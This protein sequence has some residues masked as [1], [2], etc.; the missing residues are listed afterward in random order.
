VQAGTDAATLLIASDNPGLE[1]RE[2]HAAGGAT[3]PRGEPLTKWYHG[4]GGELV[5]TNC[6][7]SAGD[8][9]AKPGA[10][11]WPGEAAGRGSPQAAAMNIGVGRAAFEAAVEYAKLR[12]QGAKP[13]IQHQAIGTILA[14]AATKLE[15]AR[16]MVRNAAWAADHPEAYADRSLADLPLQ[17]IAGVYTAEAMYEVA[18]DSA[19]CFGAMGVMLDMPLPKYV[20][21]TRVFLH[22][23]NSTAVSHFR[24]A[25]AVAGYQRS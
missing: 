20:H 5:F 19:E 13:I 12:V 18:E 6:R 16:N 25:E 10:G 21:E 4:T 22:S 24:I 1:V 7:V 15:V 11:P 17:T 9:L 23:G 3:G 2:P 14:K 8:V